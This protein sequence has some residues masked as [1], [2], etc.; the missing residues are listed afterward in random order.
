MSIEYAPPP[1][2]SLF[3]GPLLSSEYPPPVRL[4]WV[5]VLLPFSLSCSCRRFRSFA[6]ADRPSRTTLGAGICFGALS[7]CWKSFSV[8]RSA[9]CSNIHQPFNT[10]GNILSKV[11]FYRYTKV[12]DG[13]T[14]FHHIFVAQFFN[15]HIRIHSGFMKNLPGHCIP[16]TI[17][18]CQRYFYP[19]FFWKVYPR[20]TRHYPCLCLCRGLLHITRNRLFRL[21]ML[22]FS[23]IFFTDDLTFILLSKN[24]HSTRKS[25]L[26]AIGNSPTR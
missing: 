23:H 8:A 18:I 9:I 21:T 26:Y 13:I 22:H 25:L 12:L 5:V 6:N 1:K 17:N 10:H 11:P 14:D 24:A 2:A 3:W 16:N 19:F 7:S 15:A 20:Y 4:L